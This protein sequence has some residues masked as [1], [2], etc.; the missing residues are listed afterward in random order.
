[1]R[2]SSPKHTSWDEPSLPT[3]QTSG[4][5][6]ITAGQ[7]IFGIIYLRPGHIRADFT[8]ATVRELML[9]DVEITPPFIP[10]LWQ[11]A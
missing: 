2:L 3:T 7:P 5:P 6:A 9:A 11:L 1:M 4:T 8:I 10:M